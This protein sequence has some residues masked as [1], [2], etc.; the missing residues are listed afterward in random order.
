MAH[1]A[2][3][4][5]C[6]VIMVSIVLAIIAHL[7]HVIT[8]P[9]VHSLLTSTHPHWVAVTVTTAAVLVPG[10]ASRAAVKSIIAM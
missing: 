2:V 10:T 5:V 1:L 9:C 7:H 4:Y 8:A 6:L 3:F